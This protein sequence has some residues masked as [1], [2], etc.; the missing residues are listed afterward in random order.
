MRDGSGEPSDEQRLQNFLLSQLKDVSDVQISNLLR[1]G[2]G[3]SRENWPFDV[4]W[5]S[6][7]AKQRHKW[8]MRRD[9]PTSV[10]DTGREIEYKLLKALRSTDVPAPSAYWLDAEGRW[11]DR[12]FMIV[13][14]HSGQAH[15][16]LLRDSNPLALPAGTQERLARRMVG[17]LAQVHRVD[18]DA[19]GIAEI[20]PEG[21]AAPAREELEFWERELDRVELEPSPTV[22]LLIEWLRDR[23]PPPPERHVLVHGD[24]RPANVL[25][26]EGDIEVLLDWELARIG[27]PIDD[28]GWY[29]APLYN[30]EH[31]IPGIWEKQDFLA[32]YSAL[33]GLRVDADH[34]KFWQMMAI[35]RLAVMAVSGARSFI[36]GSERPSAPSQNITKRL[37]VDA[38]AAI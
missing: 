8:L 5:T 34:L 10:I 31:F 20:W 16:G 2:G 14:R 11:L 37:I 33:T 35:L 4:S 3:S 29:C 13:S 6:Q 36:E 24:F 28:L 18:V 15:R 17:I 30:R 26:H 19:T 22:R 23:I 12:P 9:P 1:L 38:F 21:S 32:E 25:V 7:G 27:D